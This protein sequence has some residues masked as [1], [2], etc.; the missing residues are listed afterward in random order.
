MIGDPV[1]GEGV[2]QRFLPSRFSAE[3]HPLDA[4]GLVCPDLACPRCHLSIP[5]TLTHKSPLLFSIVGAPGSGKSFL[6]TSMVWEMRSL[7]PREFGYVLTDADPTSNTILNEYERTLYLPADPDA[8]TTL[9][10]TEL[11]GELY[12]RVLMNNM[13][14]Y[15]PRPFML[16]F[17]AQPNH[18]WYERKRERLDQTMVLYDNAGEHFQPGRDSASDPGTQH[19]VSSNGLFFLFDPTRD[20][21]FRRDCESDDPQIKR[22]AAVESQETLL[23]EALQRIRRYSDYRAERDLDRPIVV[24]VS[25][26][27]VWMHLLRDKL[28]T[29]WRGGKFATSALDLDVVGITSYAV[30][31]LLLKYCPALVATAESFSSNVTYVPTSALG[32][33]PVVRDGALVVKPADI[34]PI[35]ASVPM[36]HMLAQFRMI[37]MLRRGKSERLPVAKDCRRVGHFIKLRV[38][39]TKHELDVPISYVDRRMRCPQTGA[40]FW[41]PSLESITQART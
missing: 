20:P 6:L 16:S 12:D 22:G 27:D 4:N 9:K 18:I 11:Q 1:L 38:P 41:I 39:G 17:R 13:N 3:G 35:W 10:K 23:V 40:V 7:L 28:I 8:Y 15:L 32:T 14:V 37:P 36:L 21:R 26:C 29:P 24:V 31:H 25:K 30:R 33:S 34:A 5:R 2:H 19:L